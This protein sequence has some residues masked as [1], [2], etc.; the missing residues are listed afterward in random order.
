MSRGVFFIGYRAERTDVQ[1]ALNDV[2][3]LWIVLRRSAVHPACINNFYFR[4][5]SVL[6]FDTPGEDL[7]QAWIATAEPA[8][9]DLFTSFIAITQ[10]QAAKAP[11]FLTEHIA[12][13]VG[14]A[15]TLTGDPLPPRTSICLS[16]RTIDLS[17][18]G[19]GRVYLPPASE[20]T[21]TDGHPASAYVTSVFDFGDL[22]LS[23][24]GDEITTALWTPMMWSEADQ[25]AKQI[26]SFFVT[27]AWRSQRDRDG[28]LSA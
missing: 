1:V 13:F 17:R 3:R 5:D 6:I 28:I 8:Y 21:N 9:I 27:P 20:S 24:I 14:T 2:Y 18:R 23:G 15:G 22:L 25:E 10:Y 7:V 12:D 16:N 26:T 11:L 4:Q 19:R